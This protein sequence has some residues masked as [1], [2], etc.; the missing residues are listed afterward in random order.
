MKITEIETFVV[1]AGWRPWQFVAVRTSEGHHGL[2]RNLRR[3]HSVRDRR[4]DQRPGAGPDRQRPRSRSRAR[5]WGHV[6]HGAA[7]AGRG[8]WPK[9]SPASSSP[10][11]TSRARRWGVPRLLALRRPHPRAAVDLLVALRQLARSQLPPDQVA[12]RRRL[13]RRRAPCADDG[14]R[15]RAR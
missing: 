6:P 10:F 12:Q 5:Y 15:H 9:R 8:S 11:G 7:V 4:H 14:R 2:R 13:G 3:P 1:D